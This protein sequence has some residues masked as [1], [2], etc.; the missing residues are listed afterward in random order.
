MRLEVMNRGGISW[1]DIADMD[2]EQFFYVLH[3][4]EPKKEEKWPIKNSR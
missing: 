3:V 4:T 2:I 1:G